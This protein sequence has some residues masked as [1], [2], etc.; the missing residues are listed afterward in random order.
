MKSKGTNR[1]RMIMGAVISGIFLPGVALAEEGISAGDTSW[2]L[3]STALVLFMTIPALALFYGGLVRTKNVLSILMQCLVLT[4]LMSLLWLGGAYSLA[5]AEG[6]AFF[7]S[8]TEKFFL[9][10]VTPDTPSGSIPELV[11]FAF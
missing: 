1:W 10:G 7:G 4:A 8:F 2:V 11:F 9:R 5:F 3:T 6:N